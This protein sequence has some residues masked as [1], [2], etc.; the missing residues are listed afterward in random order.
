MTRLSSAIDEQLSQAVND[1]MEELDALLRLPSISAQG[2]AIRETA[3]LVRS[4]LAKRGFDSEVRETDGNPVVVAR[5]NGDSDRTLLFY[6]HYDVQPP[7]PLELWTSPPF[8]P[9]VRDGKLFA[10]GAGDDKGELVSRLAAIDAVLAAHDGRL[11]CNV[12]F[13]VEGE[14]EIGSPSLGPFVAENAAYLA[15]DGCI[16]EAGF[17]DD[18][19]NPGGYLG[20]R[21]ALAVE[22]S[23]KTMSRDAHS[24]SAHVLP[25]AAWRLIEALSTLTDPRDGTILI[26]GFYDGAIGPDDDDRA[27]YAR[28]PDREAQ[29]KERYGIDSYL[30]GLS[31]TAALEAVFRPTCNI[32]GVAAGYQGDGVKTV[33]PAE[34]SAKLDFRLVPGQDADD[35]L[36]KLRDHMDRNGLTD[37]K[38]EKKLA[39]NPY[40]QP[41]S[42][43]FV[44]LVSEIGTLVHSREYLIDPLIGGSGPGSYFRRFLDCVICA[45]GINYPG[46]NVHAPDEN[47]ILDLY[48]KGVRHNAHIIDRFAPMPSADD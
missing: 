35:V 25:N 3:D 42:H 4:M 31:G 29:D 26:D 1:S 41:A 10:R 32:E 11:P 27:L 30:Y 44:E 5:R 17:V 34:A 39:I 46:M 36:G 2:T 22:L 8:E 23:V 40:K 47:I 7:E 20:M 33:I 19:G 24:M 12:T 21:G 48:E 6:N 45:A 38:V 14:E 18:Q 13:L 28:L 9:T 43:P 15:C 16:W 37:V